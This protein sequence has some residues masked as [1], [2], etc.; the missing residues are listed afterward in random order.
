[1]PFDAR[2]VERRTAYNDDMD[3]A[4]LCEGVGEYV[5]ASEFD[6]CAA[7]LDEARAEVEK[8]KGIVGEYRNAHAG[9]GCLSGSVDTRCSTCKRA[10]EASEEK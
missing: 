5:N 4:E 2:K 8:L 10:D 9:E 7:A 6:A 1:M 3:C